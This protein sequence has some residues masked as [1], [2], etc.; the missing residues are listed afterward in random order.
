VAA[1]QVEVGELFPQ[2]EVL[3]G[4][5]GRSVACGDEEQGEHMRIRAFLCPGWY[6]SAVCFQ[7]PKEVAR[8][9]Y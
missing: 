4:L 8:L 9:S 2:T 7:L 6:A 1:L 3:A 5:I